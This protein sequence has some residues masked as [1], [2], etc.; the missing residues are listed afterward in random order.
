MDRGQNLIQATERESMWHADRDIHLH[1]VCRRKYATTG[2]SRRKQGGGQTDVA[3][4]YIILH[5]ER[6]YMFKQDNQW[7]PAGPRT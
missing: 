7:V 6:H 2:C 5:K 4:A 1:R 3:E